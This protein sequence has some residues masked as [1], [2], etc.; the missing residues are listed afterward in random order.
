[1]LASLM[2]SHLEF[3]SLHD[4]GDCMNKRNVTG[5]SEIRALMTIVCFLWIDW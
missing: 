5:G 2:E 4:L 3:V 1:M